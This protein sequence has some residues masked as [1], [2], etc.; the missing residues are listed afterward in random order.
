[1]KPSVSALIRLSANAPE[2]FLEPDESPA[3]STS[4]IAPL[5]KTASC[6]SLAVT[7]AELALIV[8]RE[9]M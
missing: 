9:L 8:P 5:T 7:A 6:A 4:A 3:F 1:M 2:M